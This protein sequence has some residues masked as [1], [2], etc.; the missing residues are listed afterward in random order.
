MLYNVLPPLI[1]FTSLGGMIL[2]VSRVILR[3]QNQR[4]TD[5]IKST[6]AAVSDKQVQR[7]KQLAR[8][9][10]P[11]QKSVHR[12][13]NRLSLV[14]HS[15]RQSITAIKTS[16]RHR[17]HERSP[18]PPASPSTPQEDAGIQA[19]SE[20][21]FRHR[22]ANF[23]HQA[24]TLTKRSTFGLANLTRDGLIT[25]KE[26]RQKKIAAKKQAEES[27]RQSTQAQ[28]VGPAPK[29]AV[30]L[31]VGQIK[32][33]APRSRQVGSNTDQPI[34]SKKIFRHK[35]TPHKLS[36]QEV[37][38]VLEKKQY[39][40]V[41]DILVPFLAANPRNVNAYM[42]LGQAAA[43]RGNWEEAVEIF[44]QVISLDP[45]ARTCYAYLGQALFETGNITRAIESLQRAHD[46]D[47]ANQTVIECLLTI[48]E[49][50]DNLTMQKSL[51]AELEQLKEKE[52]Q[53]QAPV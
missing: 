3:I 32:N 18:A 12:I 13:K 52:T 30:S 20:S 29:P 49:R 22:L 24:G 43:A 48:A 28:N 33:T 19:P 42:L 10:G 27:N 9:I 15:I 11:S 46:E 35:K 1:F 40:R 5:E 51:K 37:R 31:S 17:A 7:S 41:E 34:K 16:R 26:R 47:P 45:E 50:Q 38:Q 21:Q 44:E 4:I 6:V 39:S 36:L 25:L 14:S 23:G 53:S 2:V 8:V